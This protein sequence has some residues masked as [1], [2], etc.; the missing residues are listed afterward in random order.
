[1]DELICKVCT[2]SNTSESDSGTSL[3]FR[4]KMLH[5]HKEKNEGYT[6]ITDS[7]KMKATPK[8]YF[9]TKGQRMKKE[10]MENDPKWLDLKGNV[11]AMID[12]ALKEEKW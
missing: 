8:D 12:S 11:Q 1:M 3:V 10:M 6:A 7:E 9:V 2:K 4:Q 5:N